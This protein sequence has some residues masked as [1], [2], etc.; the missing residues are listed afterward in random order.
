M[1]TFADQA[2]IL[3]GSVQSQASPAKSPEELTDAV[4]TVL[5]WVQCR[6]LD[7]S[8]EAALRGDDDGH[9]R[10]GIL[11]DQNAMSIDRVREWR[12]E[13]NQTKGV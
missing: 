1:T 5:S 9:Q 12:R 8:L 4:L 6:V 2:K 13:L 11:M 3:L 7:Y 10:A